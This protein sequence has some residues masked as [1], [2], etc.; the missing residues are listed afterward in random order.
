MIWKE[1]ILKVMENRKWFSRR[2][3]VKALGL[4]HAIDPN[5]TRCVNDY[6]IQLVRSGHIE[7]AYAPNELKVDPLDHV[8]YVYR[9]TGK[10]WVKK[11]SYPRTPLA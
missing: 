5:R 9:R 11:K 8:M 4:G 2:M 7:R 1:K 3:I 10:P 6:L